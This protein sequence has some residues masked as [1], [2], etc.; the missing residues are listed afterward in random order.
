MRIG[1]LGTTN[2]IGRGVVDR[3]GSLGHDVVALDR[4]KK[5]MSINYVSIDLRSLKQ[6]IELKLDSLVLL[7]WIGT[8]RNS[9]T[10]DINVRAYKHLASELRKEGTFPVFISSMTAKSPSR[11]VHSHA[12]REVESLFMGWGSILRL[13]QVLTNSGSVAGKSA[14]KSAILTKFGRAIRTDL[15]IPSVQ[16]ESVVD[17]VCSVATSRSIS[18]CE[19]VDQ[20]HQVGGKSKA[21]PLV[22]RKT[23]ENIVKISALLAFK[24]RTNIIDRWYA[25]VDSQ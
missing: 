22:S 10:M 25:L 11:S 23:L 13:G 7:S 18:V 4:Q 17:R 12:K 8:P 2:E 3:L 21:A 14:K 24:Q 20:Y 15:L 9:E 16:L 5:S 6:P 19:L 1:V